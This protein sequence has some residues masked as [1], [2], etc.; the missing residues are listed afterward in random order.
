MLLIPAF[1]CWILLYRVLRNVEPDRRAAF[2]HAS[3]YW[4]LILFAIT[5]LLS[6]WHWITA[7]GLAIAWTVACGG[8]LV[9]GRLARRAH[10]PQPK[11]TPHF[12]LSNGDWLL[13]ACTTLASVTRGGHRSNHARSFV[14]TVP[15]CRR[16]WRNMPGRPPRFPLT[17]T[18]YSSST[19]KETQQT[20]DNFPAPGIF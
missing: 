11:A 1:L 20:C 5:E 9:L 16:N 13:L 19:A 12:G 10:P 4:G 15:R 18:T 14:S 8:C 17:E 6:F 7:P 3:V 2:V